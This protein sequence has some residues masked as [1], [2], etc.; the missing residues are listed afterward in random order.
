MEASPGL[1][2]EVEAVAEEAA[3]L[4]LE[5]YATDFRYSVRARRA[6]YDFATNRASMVDGVLRTQDRKGIPLV[7]RARELRQYSQQQFEATGVRVS[8]S[9]FFE[10][11]LSIGAERATITEVESWSGEGTNRISPRNVTFH[12]GG[13]PFFCLP[14]F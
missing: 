14:V 10:P 4:I 6:Y 5:V 7:A 2:A 9:E 3:A 8:M 11:H 1:L 13:V 12:A